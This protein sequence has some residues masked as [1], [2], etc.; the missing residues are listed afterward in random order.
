M[1]TFMKIPFVKMQGTGNDFVMF[2]GVTQVMCLTHPQIRKIADRHYGI[3]C[4]QLL[5][6]ERA[7]AKHADFRFRI[8][9]SDGGEAEQCGNGL[10]CFARFVRAQGLT[11]KDE[12]VVE[13]LGGEVHTRLETDGLVSVNMGVPA[14]DPPLIPFEAP[15]RLPV[16]ELVVGTESVNISAVSIGNPHAVQM[17][18]D[19]DQAPVAV[20]GPLIERHSRF[21]K[22]AN[23]GF[24][25][26][27]DRQR[28]RLRVYE[29][30]A[31]ETLACGTGACAAVVAGSLRGLLDGRI[32]V[33]LPGGKLWVT[34][35][36]EGKEVWMMGPAVTVFEGTI[37]LENL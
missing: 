11:K 35:A 21:P 24:M 36:G 15:E 37:D 20:Q 3:G 29:R 8:F 33:Q 16:Y 13:T 4:D 32:E 14:F 23:A 27:I 28:I 12:L 26:I 9:N 25:Q 30:G 18:A 34:W 22:R 31:G 19:V 6:V 7:Q 5:I 1:L 2:D 17:V 10:R